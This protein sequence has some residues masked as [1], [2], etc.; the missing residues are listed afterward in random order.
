M[1][2][3]TNMDGPEDDSVEREER[4]FVTF[5]VQDEIFAAPMAPVQEIIRLPDLARVPL[6]PPSLIGLANLRGRVLPIVDLRQIFELNTVAHTDATR[7]LVINFG[8]PLGFVVDRVSSV[9][10]V[11]PADIEP[12]STIR[13]AIRDDLLTG[14][15]RAQDGRLIMVIDFERIISSEFSAVMERQERQGHAEVIGQGVDADEDGESDEL[16]LVSFSVHG[17]EYAADIAA[18]QEI[19]QMPPRITALPKASHHVLGL[20]TLRERLLPL[21]SMRALLALPPASEGGMQRVVVLALR[22][23]N[24][25]GVVADSVDEVL[26]VPRQ[27]VEPLPGLLSQNNG[28]EEISSVCRLDGGRRLVSV[29]DS[30]RMF[31]QDAFRHAIDQVSQMEDTMSDQVSDNDDVGLEDEEQVVVFRLG[32]EEFGVPISSVQEIVRVPEQLTHVPK[33]PGFVEGVI[34]LRGSVLPV[35][36]QRRRLG[37]DDVERNDRQRIMVYLLDGSRMGFIV[38]AVSEVLKI[39]RAAIEEAPHL[40]GEQRRMLGRVAN[41]E[42]QRRMILLIEPSAL[43]TGTEMAEVAK[44]A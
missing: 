16:Q 22:G 11:D 10:A 40:S 13:S 25:V 17:Q 7:A 8:T 4:Q 19:V 41:L 36:D 3:A 23:G 21:V 42:K 1:Q 34:N 24:A 30:N 26:R 32:S 27:L 39:P 43:L 5:V 18:V 6:S 14:V 29:I 44:V 20:M 37:L 31:D 28:I 35:M 33:A 12:V 2:E 9:I 15:V 38:D